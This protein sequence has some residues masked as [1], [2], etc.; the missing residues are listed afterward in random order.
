MIEWSKQW[1]FP[2]E[3]WRQRTCGKEREL[4]IQYSLLSN[5]LILVRYDRKI[6]KA[7]FFFFFHCK[8]W[9]LKVPISHFSFALCE[10]GN[11]R[12]VLEPCDTEVSWSGRWASKFVERSPQRSEEL[13]RW[14]DWTKICY[15]NSHVP[16]L[17]PTPPL[18]FWHII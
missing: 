17:F 8:E 12:D 18:L 5:S 11:S 6:Q 9:L 14:E 7:T 1:Q 4:K 10:N 15:P 16:Y 2:R 13:E 3:S